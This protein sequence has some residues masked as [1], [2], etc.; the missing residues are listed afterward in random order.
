MKK[1]ISF[2]RDATPKVLQLYLELNQYPI[3]SKRILERMRREILARGVITP[4]DFEEE[5]R[6]KALQS[7][8][9]EGLDNPQEQES[10]EVWQERV[11]KTRDLLTTFYFAHNLP[12]DLFK[13]IVEELITQQAPERQVI[14]TFNPE[15]APWDLLFQQGALYENAPPEER[16]LYEHHLQEMIV[17]LVKSLI[18]DQLAFVEVARQYFTMADL[19]EIRRRRIGRG[20]IGGKS[21]G[22]LLAYKILQQE[23]A[24]RGINIG[25]LITLP[26]SFF[27]G[28]DVYTDFKS[29]SALF[30]FMNQKYK[31]PE[32]I[33]QDFPHVR[34][35]YLKGSLPKYA[36][37]RLEVLL[38]EVGNAPLIVRS[39]SLLEDNFNTSF[40]GKY[41]SFFLPN[42]GTREENLK[43]LVE[44]IIQV[45]AS[46]LS[47]DA[48]IYRQRMGLRNYD[49]RMAVLIQKVEGQ[50]YGPYFFPAFAGVAFG[51]NPYRWS[52][53]IRAE[54][55]LVRIVTGLGTRAVERV[56]RDYPRMVALSHPE[57]RPERGTSM[58]KH[59]SQHRMDVLNLQKNTFETLPV[60]EVLKVDY[61]GLNGIISVDRD[62]YL[63]VPAGRL[64]S[65]EPHQMVV[66]FDKLLSQ[67]PFVETM[68]TAMAILGEAYQRPVDMEFTGE[69]ET[70]YPVPKIRIALLQCR[71]QSRRHPDKP[72]DI[73]NNIPDE[74]ILFTANQQVPQGCVEGIRYIVYVDPRVYTRVPDRR[75]R[76]EIGTV[77]GHLNQALSDQTFILMGPGR[78]GSAN[79]QLGVKVTYTD[80]YN[81]RALI[82][83]AH[84]EGGSVPEVS[85]GT[86][87]FQDLVEAHIHPLPLYPEDPTVVYRDD[88]FTDS[89]NVLADLLPD[90]E[91][92]TP[93]V[94]VIDVLAVSGA[95]T[96]TLMMNSEEEKAIGYLVANQNGKPETSTNCE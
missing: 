56:G 77:V 25:E 24:K 90:W 88:F 2:D 63:Q 87:F 34:A 6:E 27:L 82:E 46:V 32:E 4:K 65:L 76:L 80:I 42:Q 64:L 41:D 37:G 18:S 71:P 60:S 10:P 51:H 83:I 74:D 7:Q 19:T 50:Q 28:A 53:R 8:I 16:R 91:A 70:T 85:Y 21:A 79:L 45:F 11:E 55:G 52:K 26:E 36:M 40:A 78:W 68:R 43:A 94:S 17:V 30:E 62:G 9:H 22:M 59:Y 86:H 29:D 89:P 39:S 61:H 93:Y 72:F 54:D 69:F 31:D 73:P 38:D 75:T 48:L 47:P 84:A 95:K 13:D 20:K 33:K 1:T 57:L 66:T 44:A 67:G 58:V 15:L 14:L 3:L 49:E 5:V 12:H 81:T 92:F 23:G 96:M 35:A